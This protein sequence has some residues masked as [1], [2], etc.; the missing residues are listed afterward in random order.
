[1]PAA[2]E[3]GRAAWLGAL[4][5]V[6]EFLPISSDGHIAI[7][8]AMLGFDGGGLAETVLLH[9]GT[10]LA[11]LLVLRTDV[12]ITARD[13]IAAIRHPEARDARPAREA[14]MVLL[15]SV[16]TAVIGLLLKDVVEVWS[17]D[18]R[19]VG[20]FLLVSAVFVAGSHFVRN[21]TNEV[22]DIRGALLVGIL[23]GLA[24]LP[25]WSRSATT[26]ASAMALGLSPSA[27]FRFSFL[28]SLP[29]VAGACL[30]ELRDPAV[31]EALGPTAWFGAVIS[32]VTGAAAL[33]LL[34]GV[35]TS[36]RFAYF[37]VY[38]I[39]LGLSLATGVVAASAD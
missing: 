3:V 23:Q 30:L 15:A 7:A 16:P 37:A 8:R 6:T 20:G 1:M 34:R 12:A 4:Q 29:A 14:Q 21:R 22:L 31:V 26:I 27:A 11:T 33:R 10:L 38:L 9:V 13:S 35:V 25:G 17:S 18:V 24:V 32:F 2:F 5:G 19:V 36:G 39:P 28:L